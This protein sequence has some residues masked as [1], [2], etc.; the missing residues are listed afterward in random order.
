MHRGRGRPQILPAPAQ[1]GSSRY[2]Y[3]TET[4][5]R[6]QL[7]YSTSRLFLFLFLPPGPTLLL[8]ALSQKMQRSD[9]YAVSVYKNCTWHGS[10]NMVGSNSKDLLPWP[11]ASLA[12]P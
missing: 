4:P 12:N 11:W 6:S 9:G 3:H 10:L 7:K 5:Y 8:L 1:S 2:L